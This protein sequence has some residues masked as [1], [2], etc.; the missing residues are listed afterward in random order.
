[1]N[2]AQQLAAAFQRPLKDVGTLGDARFAGIYS[3]VYDAQ[4][5]KRYMSS[6]YE[7]EA[8]AEGQGAKLDLNDYY[9]DLLREALER[10]GGVPEAPSALILEIGCGF[11]SATFP[12]L[13]LFPR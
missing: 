7:S 4:E 12:I 1:M 2:A 10:S 9:R 13:E 3:P 5:V 8:G 11:G 6:Y